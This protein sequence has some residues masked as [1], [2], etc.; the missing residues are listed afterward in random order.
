MGALDRHCG[1]HLEVHDDELYGQN[2]EH[3]NRDHP[4][5]QLSDEPVRGIVAE[6]G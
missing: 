6:G 4:E 5:M 1:K 2:R 3:V